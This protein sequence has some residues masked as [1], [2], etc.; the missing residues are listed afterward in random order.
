V[1]MQYKTSK[2]RRIRS[3][4]RSRTATI[5][6]QPQHRGEALVFYLL[7]AIHWNACFY[8]L[9]SA[10]NGFGSDGWVYVDINETLYPKNAT[11]LKMYSYRSIIVRFLS[12]TRCR[13]DVTVGC[14]SVCLSVCPV[15]RQQQRR[16]GMDRY[17]VQAPALSSKCGRI[18]YV[19]LRAEGLGSRLNTD[20]FSHFSRAFEHRSI[21]H[22][23]LSTRLYLTHR[24]CLR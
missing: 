1:I 3:R 22:V 5:R 19:L 16:V 15:D 14:P 12:S 21:N 7:T 9:M 2:R 11:L 10:Y 23:V 4:F 8:F 17:L 20:I 6:T 18:V 24:A 13:V